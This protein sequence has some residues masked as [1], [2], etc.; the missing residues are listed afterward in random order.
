[1]E[2]KGGIKKC[3]TSTHR[4]FR[5]LV[6][7]ALLLAIRVNAGCASVVRELD[8]SGPDE[9]DVVAELPAE[10]SPVA[11]IERPDEDVDEA[12]AQ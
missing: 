12:Q 6:R 9:R 2:K 8:A 7:R 11:G 4:A 10:R 3:K 1:M 5:R